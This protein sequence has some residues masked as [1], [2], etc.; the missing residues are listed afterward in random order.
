MSV[1]NQIGRT[2]WTQLR[3]LDKWALG[4]WGA[5]D[6]VYMKDGLKFKTSGAV[7]FKGYVY[8]QL[9]QGRDLYNVIF[10]KVRKFEWKEDSRVEGVYADQLVKI[11]DRKVLGKK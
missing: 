5:K 4:D 7:K 2:I 6:A 11:I 8:I 3:Q 9:D 1:S 10:A